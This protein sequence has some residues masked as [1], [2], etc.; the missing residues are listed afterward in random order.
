SKRG[1]LFRMNHEGREATKALAHR[2]SFDVIGAAIEVHRRLGPGL[3]ESMYERCLAR[4]LQLRGVPYQREVDVP[5]VYRG[6]PIGCGY[7]VDFVIDECL[8]LELKAGAAIAPIRLNYLPICGW[9]VSRSASSSTSTSES[10]G[11]AFG[12]S[13]ATEPFA[14]FL[15]L[16]VT[17]G[18]LACNRRLSR[19]SLSAD[20]S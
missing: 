6:E 17:P 15:P 11:A 1:Q 16:W 3:L 4:E 19:L 12:D 20:S 13:S 5:V 14:S 9:S 7:R 18:N 10:C 2:L 8:L